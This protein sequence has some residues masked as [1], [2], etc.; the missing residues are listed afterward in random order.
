MRIITAILFTLIAPIAL[1][2]GGGGGMSAPMSQPE[3]KSPAQLA[4]DSYNRGIRNRDKAWKYQAQAA[5]SDNP[6]KI[7]KFEKKA[8]K[9]FANAAKRF[10]AA[11]KHNSNLYQAHSSLGYALRKT[12]DYTASLAAYDRAIAMNPRYGEAIEYRGETYLALGELDKTREAYLQLVKIDP[13]LAGE[14][15]T[16]IQHWLD[17]SPETVTGDKLQSFKAWASDRLALAEYLPSSSSA[18]HWRQP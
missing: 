15:M 6:K 12:G 11:I 16:A 2:S 3:S 9:Q 10:R 7:A 14:L 1:A 13:K 5:K 4:V 8:L 18:D 17:S